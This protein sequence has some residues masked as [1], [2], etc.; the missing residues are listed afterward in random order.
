MIAVRPALRST[1]GEGAVAPLLAAVVVTVAELTGRRGV[2]LAASVYRVDRFRA[3]GFSLWDFSWFGGHWTLGY[4]VL[5]PPLAAT[6]GIAALTVISATAAALGFDRL[7]R[8][9][10][11]AG[12]WPAS[13]LFAAGTVVPAAI[14]QLPFLTGE[15]FGLLALWAL[16]RGSRA[17]RWAAP[18]LALSS[19]LTSPLSGAFVALAAVAWSLAERAVW[20]ERA[21]PGAAVAVAALLPTGITTL[22]FPG[23]GPMPYPVGDFAW[24]MVVAAAVAALA[25][26]RRPEVRTGALLLAAAALF[27]EVVPSALGGNVGR[28]EDVAALPLAV[29]LAWDGRRALAPAL[30]VPLAL[31]QWVPAWGALTRI[32]S[33][34]ST[35]AAYFAPLDRE[36]AGLEAT[37]PAGRVEVVP[38]AYHWEAAY[39]P[40]VMPLARGWERQLDEA[41]NPLFYRGGLTAAAYRAW[42]VDNGVRFVALPSAPL[43]MAGR[44]EGALVSSGRVPGLQLAWSS[45]NWRLYSVA[46]SPGIVTGPGRL[47]RT[48]GRRV[49]VEATGAGR[50]LLRI[51]WSR[52]WGVTGGSGCVARADGTWTA[53]DVPAAG[54]VTL[55]LVTPPLT[56]PPCRSASAT[57]PPVRATAP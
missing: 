5:Y 54:Q 36:L 16:G 33:E 8:A 15:A 35:S 13:I 10:L 9:R 37:G 49:T 25:W 3:R 20:G 40:T 7:V 41:D 50:L 12:G 27:A 2:D 1:S 39:V 22:L 14:G 19:T 55:A 24:E 53:L 30:A 6:V 18:L 48:D 47:V 46:G 45:G 31:S 44:A 57:R 38:T 34:P 28:I 52:D 51:R 26:R 29:G 11:G 17:A 42:L 4:S 23:E 32:P 56:P 21:G 43:D